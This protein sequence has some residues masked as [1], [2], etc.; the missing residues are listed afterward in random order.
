MHLNPVK[1]ETRKVT[2]EKSDSGYT[3]HDSGLTITDVKFEDGKMT[4]TDSMG[5]SYV[6]TKE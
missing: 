3:I 5:M 1:N 2:L 4:Y 6:F